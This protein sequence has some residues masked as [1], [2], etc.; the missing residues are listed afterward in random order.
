[1]WRSKCI[2]CKEMDEYIIVE[3]KKERKEKRKDSLQN[4]SCPQKMFTHNV[5]RFK[6]HF[7]SEMYFNKHCLDNIQSVL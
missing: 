7:Q 3:E 1:M 5:C 4:T 6:L 2:Y